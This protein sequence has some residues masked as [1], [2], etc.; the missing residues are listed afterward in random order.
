[1][2]GAPGMS[3]RLGLR[4][5]YLM[6]MATVTSVSAWLLILSGHRLANRTT[7]LPAVVK[8]AE[9]KYSE[10]PLSQAQYLTDVIEPISMIESHSFD[11]GGS[12]GLVFRD[13]K[14]NEKLITLLDNLYDEHNL[15]FGVCEGYPKGGSRAPVAGIDEKAFLGLLERWYRQDPDATKWNDRIDRWLSSGRG[16]SEGFNEVWGEP[17]AKLEAVCILRALRSRN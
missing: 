12:I 1:M 3:V 10:V 17:L 2:F 4:T 8:A 16:H 6:V 5:K 9:G 14:G 11:D 7:P 13:S 15:V